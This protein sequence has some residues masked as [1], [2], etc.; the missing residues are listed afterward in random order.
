MT[1]S[2]SICCDEKTFYVFLQFVMHRH[3]SANVAFAH[4]IHLIAWHGVVTI[5]LEARSFVVPALERHTC[6]THSIV[7]R[8]GMAGYF[9]DPHLTKQGLR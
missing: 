2:R 4:R 5:A 3:R 6:I 7:S 9:F 1:I 8:V